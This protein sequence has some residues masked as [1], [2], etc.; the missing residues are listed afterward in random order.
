MIG[1]LALALRA[2]WWRRGASAVVLVVAVFATGTAAAG[3]VF[4]QGASESILHDALTSAPAT[5]AGTG[6]E[7]TKDAT[8]RSGS[9]ALEAAVTQAMTGSSLAGHFHRRVVSLEHT[10]QVLDPH[11]ASLGRVTVV[12]RDG[13]CGQ[14]RMLTGRCIADAAS[15]AGA[16]S[17]VDEVMVSAVDAQRLKWAAGQTIT[18]ASFRD[19]LTPAGSPSRQ[20]LLVGTYLPVDS[21][22]GYWFNDTRHYFG[23]DDRRVERAQHQPAA[24]RTLEAAFVQPSAFAAVTASGSMQILVVEDLLLDPDS[25]TSARVPRLRKDLDA[26]AV[27]LRTADLNQGFC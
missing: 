27:R 3:P 14:V 23:G 11:G 2:I 18:V 5:S 25:L 13:V 26:F 9:S 22:G 6:A 8:G 15:T 16:G 7:V 1:A 17:G 4:L 19:V 21:G 10:T 20:L 24:D 12:A